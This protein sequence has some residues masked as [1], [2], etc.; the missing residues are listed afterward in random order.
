MLPGVGSADVFVPH[1]LLQ[2]NIS[3]GGYPLLLEA[4]CL[5]FWGTIIKKNFLHFTAQD[6]V[7]LQV[8]MT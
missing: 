4:S 5:A 8:N 3:F 6:E 2:C 1:P 7:I